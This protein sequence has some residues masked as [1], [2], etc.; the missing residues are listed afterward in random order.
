MKHNKLSTQGYFIKRLK[1]NGYVVWRIF[2]KYG[3]GDSR[4]WTILVNPGFHSTY[5]TCHVNLEMINDTPA[6][7]F[8][9]G[10]VYIRSDL[11]IQTNSFETIMNHMMKSGIDPSSQHFKKE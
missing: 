5:I 9:D 6:F 1:D 10:G 3:L 2:D 4:K 11:K 7:S 8:E